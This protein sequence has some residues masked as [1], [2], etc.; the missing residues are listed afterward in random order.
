MLDLVDFNNWERIPLVYGGD[1]GRKIAVMDVRD[2]PWM[3]KFPESS[4]AA[5]GNTEFRMTSPLAEWLGSHVYE[6]AGV[7]VHE[8]VLGVCGG[9]LVC[10]CRDFTYPD[11]VLYEFHD[12]KNSISDDEPGYVGRPSDGSSLC[13]S[14]VL[15]TVRHLP[16]PFATWPCL[17]RFWDMFVVDGLIGNADRSNRNWGFLSRGGELV[18][19]TPVYDNGNSFFNVKPDATEQEAL[20]AESLSC[21]TDQAGRRVSPMRYISDGADEGCMRACGRLLERLDLSAVDSLIDS[22]PEQVAGVV[23]LPAAAK[24]FHKGVLRRRLEEV[25]R[26]A[27]CTWSRSRRLFVP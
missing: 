18:G 17:D 6:L 12:V 3:V 23:I 11:L 25:I 16:G 22:A 19:L 9:K 21:Y 7:P 10:A 4:R 13:M 1:A 8:T 27:Y 26:P 2:R 5:H 15:N 20:T 24:G 14:D